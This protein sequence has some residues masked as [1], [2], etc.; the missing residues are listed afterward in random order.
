M[1][2]AGAFGKL[3]M[4]IAAEKIRKLLMDSDGTVGINLMETRHEREGFVLLLVYG[5]LEHVP[6][7]Y[8]GSFRPV[9]E[10]WD[11]IKS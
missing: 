7:P 4:E 5:W 6:V 1:A 10:F 3:E 9:D 2:L 8:P 11:R